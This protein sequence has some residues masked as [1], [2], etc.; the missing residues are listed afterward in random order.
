MSPK[1]YIAADTGTPKYLFTTSGGISIPP[2]EAPA[3]TTIPRE[4]PIRRP[5]KNVF[6]KISSVTE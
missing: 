6:R 2:V 1:T 5:A 3:L 4:R